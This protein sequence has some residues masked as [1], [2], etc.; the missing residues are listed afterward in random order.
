[1]L[2]LDQL[3]DVTPVVGIAIL[4]EQNDW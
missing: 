1:M 4:G 3:S 2:F